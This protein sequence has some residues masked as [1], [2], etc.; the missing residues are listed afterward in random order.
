M[1]LENVNAF[2]QIFRV[3]FFPPINYPVTHLYIEACARPAK[4]ILD[5][6]MPNL[7]QPNLIQY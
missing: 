2:F 1:I 3:V 5:T 6:L 7:I 4:K